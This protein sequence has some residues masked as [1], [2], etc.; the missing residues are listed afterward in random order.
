MPELRPAV[1]RPVPKYVS[2]GL[3]AKFTNFI[4]VR[5]PQRPDAGTPNV[6]DVAYVLNGMATH[7]AAAAASGK[8]MRRIGDDDDGALAVGKVLNTI[9]C[10]A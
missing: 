4:C 6:F 9:G 5:R 7:R 1:P 10:H 2:N 3:N 8:S